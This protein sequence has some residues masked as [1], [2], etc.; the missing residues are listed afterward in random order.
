METNATNPSQLGDP[1]SLKA[2][3][4]STSPTASDR[5]SAA[6]SPSSA[7]AAIQNIKKV[8]PTPTEGDGPKRGGGSGSGNGNGEKTLRQRAMNKLEENPSQLGDPVSLKAETA[9]SEPTSEDRGARS[10]KSKL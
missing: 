10:G 8:A 2:E 9:D 1:V 7:G 6:S 3:T 4:S 5:G